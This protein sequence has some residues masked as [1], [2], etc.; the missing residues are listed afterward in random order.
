MRRTLLVD[1]YNVLHA[2]EDLTR[3]AR[4]FGIERARSDLIRA[5]GTYAARNGCDCTVVFDGV[6]EAYPAVPLVKV[7]FSGTRSADAV[8][9]DQVRRVGQRFIVVTSDRAVGVNARMNLAESIPSSRLVSDLSLI[10]TER[11][12]EESARPRISPHRLDELR[13]RSEKPDVQDEDL[14]DWLKFFGEEGESED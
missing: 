13:E 4:A 6:V 5:L 14:D 7:L 12:E 1:G 9:A 2:S 8:I 3:A 10:L 11:D